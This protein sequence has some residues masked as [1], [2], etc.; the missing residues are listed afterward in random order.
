MIFMSK[1][2]NRWRCVQKSLFTDDVSLDDKY[3]PKHQKL[4]VIFDCI[5]IPEFTDELDGFRGRPKRDRSA[6]LA[7]FVAK[8]VWNLPTTEALIDRLHLDK[9][10][11]R[12][13]LFEVDKKLPCKATFSNAFHEFSK[14]GLAQ[15]IHTFIVKQHFKTQQTQ[16]VSRDSTDISVRSK[17]IKKD[18]PKWKR[19]KGRNKTTYKQA[20]IPLQSVLAQI[21]KENDV[22]RK[23][24]YVW[25]GHKLHLD[26]ADGDIP[27]TA[28]LSSASVHDSQLAIPLERL[29][30]LRLISKFTL[31]DSA[32]DSENI[33][34]FIAS[35]NKQA[36]INPAKRKPQIHYLTEKQR[37]IYDQRSSVERV[38]GH[39]KD[40]FGGRHVR[41]KGPDKVMTHLM[42]GICAIT[43]LKIL[44]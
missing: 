4:A 13:C 27:V 18:K 41:V 35:C 36:L 11:R 10:L 1:I 43:A 22:G 37:R 6:L 15:Q 39:L 20:R 7:A 8:A 25:W 23:G 21:P 24:H 34:G 16:T 12:L 28:L 33:R 3:S 32:Y 2:Q 44:N 5:D 9:V 26:V 42:M 31:M 40:N 14:L 19:K 30:N 29:T 38:F 17:R